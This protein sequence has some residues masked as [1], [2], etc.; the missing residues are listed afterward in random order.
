MGG[1]AA[2]SMAITNGSGVIAY[3]RVGVSV[4][5]TPIPFGAPGDNGNYFITNGAFLMF[6]ESAGTAAT[7]TVAYHK[8]SL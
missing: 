5:T 2:V 4:S 1:T 3:S 7:M 6:L 8:V